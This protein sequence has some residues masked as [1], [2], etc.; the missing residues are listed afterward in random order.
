MPSDTKSTADESKL[1]AEDT[2]ELKF[3]CNNA[4]Y[5]HRDYTGQSNDM[6][7]RSLVLYRR[8][9]WLVQHLKEMSNEK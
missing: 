1:H 9:S 2:E 3:I 5:S 7:Q 6:P 4:S 8:V